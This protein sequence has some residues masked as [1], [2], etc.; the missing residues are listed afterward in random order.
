MLRRVTGF[1]RPYVIGFVADLFFPLWRASLKISGFDV[2]FAGCVWT[3][4]VPGKKKLGFKNIRI[5]VDG[6]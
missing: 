2:D 3:E 1:T 6:A 4:A 5:R